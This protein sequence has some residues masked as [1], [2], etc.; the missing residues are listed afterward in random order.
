MNDISTPA[1]TL[2]VTE[3]DHAL[4][5]RLAGRLDAAQS[6]AIGGPL[7]ENIATAGKAV[8]FDLKT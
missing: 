3:Q 2:D 7:A 8:V 1:S 4:I 6:A 5:V